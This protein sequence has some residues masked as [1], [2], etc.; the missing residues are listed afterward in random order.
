MYDDDIDRG[1]IMGCWVLMA[2]KVVRNA[3]SVSKSIEFHYKIHVIEYAKIQK[4]L[5]FLN[6]YPLATL[7]SVINVNAVFIFLTPT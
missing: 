5:F 6:L 3:I 4:L 2:P 7:I 1:V